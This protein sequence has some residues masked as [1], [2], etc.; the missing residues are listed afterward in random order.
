MNMGYLT[1]LT[2]VFFLIV[3][4]S[5]VVLL[6]VVAAKNPKGKIEHK[7]ASHYLAPSL[8]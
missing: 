2:P 3:A 4:A 5:V 8:M 7:A 6:G 1:L